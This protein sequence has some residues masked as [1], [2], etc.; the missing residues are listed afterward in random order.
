MEARMPLPADAKA[1]FPK[2]RRVR[3]RFGETEPIERYTAN[4]NIVFS[5]LLAMLSFSFPPGEDSFIRA[6]R[7]FSDEITD[8]ELKKRIAGF[9]GQESVHG[10]EH[11]RLNERVQAE[12]GYIDLPARVFKRMERLEERFID[13]RPNPSRFRRLLPLAW[14]AMAEHLTAIIGA[15]IL[16]E[17]EIQALVEGTEQRHLTNWHALEELEH[18]AV[19]FDVYRAVG[20]PERLRIRVMWAAIVLAI[21][22]LASVTLYSIVKTDPYGRRQPVRLVREAWQVVRGPVFKG[23]LKEMRLYTREG[24]HPNDIDTDAICLRW[25]EKLFGEQGELV[26]HLR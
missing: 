6:V 24:F 22:V 7:R 11:N 18:K 13:S 26:D 20:G 19:A 2:V 12:F 17:P 1:I 9:I 25:R 16:Q 8:P 3:F 15:R 5:H 14:T 21:P 10:Q 23:S 4:N